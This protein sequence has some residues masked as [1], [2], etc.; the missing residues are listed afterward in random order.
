MC[1]HDTHDAD[2]LFDAF[3]DIQPT[4]GAASQVIERTRQAILERSVRPD[5]VVES[6]WSIRTNRNVFAA[7]AVLVIIA[8]SLALATLFA[9]SV[10]TG[11]TQVREQLDRVRTITFDV[12]LDTPGA[13][14]ATLQVMIRNDGKSHEQYSDG[15]CVVSEQAEDAW[16]R[17]EVN[18]TKNSAH[19]TYGFPQAL[20][21]DVLSLIRDLPNSA[22]ASPIESRTIN[23]RSC[24]GFLIVLEVDATSQ[25]MRLWI[26]PE[27]HLPIHGVVTATVERKRAGGAATKGLGDSSRSAATLSNF[28][29][30]IELEDSLFALVPPEGYTVTTEGSP[31]ERRS[32]AWPAKK[33]RLSVGKGIGP[34]EFGMSREQV[35]E[36]FGQPE[37]RTEPT[38]QTQRNSVV[39]EREIWYYNSQ[40][41]V[42]T[43]ADPPGGLGSVLCRPASFTRRAF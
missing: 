37:E 7:S 38:Q 3:N 36:R 9:P 19:I 35:V 41:F 22:G 25:Q 14:V 29:Y 13:P 17:L 1:D 23:G 32:V 31:P 10:A 27:T 20:P 8:V 21:F 15:R 4:P 33:L 24:P 34:V 6:W 11:F 43:F 30:D 28:K 2:K 16:T 42:I 40:G 26:D 39:C 18:P 5:G 12:R